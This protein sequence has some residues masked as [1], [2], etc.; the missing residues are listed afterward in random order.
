MCGIYASNTGTLFENIINLQSLEYRGYDSAGFVFIDKNNRLGIYKDVGNVSKL[1]LS[2]KEQDIDILAFMG[3]T[4][5]ATHGKVTKY[6]AHPHLDATQRYFI[7]HNGIVENYQDL[8]QKYNLQDKLK[9][10]T[11][12]EVLI[13]VV[14]NHCVNNSLFDS[15]KYTMQE[16]VGANSFIIL[17]SLNYKEF[18]VCNNGSKID[19][20]IS[21]KNNTISGVYVTSNS[22]KSFSDDCYLVKFNEE[23]F[24][25]R[26]SNDIDD[27]NNLY[28]IND[29]INNCENTI[30]K[31]GYEHFML[32]EIYEQPKMVRNLYSGRLY[33]DK[34]VLGGLQDLCKNNIDFDEIKILGC[35]SSLHASYIIQRYIEEISNIKTNVEQA[36]EFRYRSPV[37]SNKEL[38][39]CI[40][41][42]GETSDILEAMK[43]IKSNYTNRMMGI[44][45]TVGSSVSALSDFGI[46]TRAGKEVGVA[47]TKTYTNQI[48]SGLIFALYFHLREEII[49]ELLDLPTVI[50]NMLDNV[51]IFNQVNNTSLGIAKKRRCIFL[52]RGYNYPTALEGALKLK[53]LTYIYAHGYSASE[54]KHGPLALIDEN[55]E[56]I[57]IANSD[58]Q[59]LKTL[60]NASEVLCRHG[61]VTLIT[62][63]SSG[64]KIN[65]IIIPNSSKYVS[66]VLSNIVC[67]LIAYQT[68]VL[69]NK[70]V[71]QPRNLAKSVTVE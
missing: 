59:Y 19:M 45:N 1:M 67:Q 41:Q 39:I 54:M 47:S 34:I 37:I 6:N 60:N 2:V 40:S 32:K 53:E 3:H 17:D 29:K 33:S 52:G 8:I 57:V 36:G 23:K 30:D 49:L 58:D 64:M 27:T 9:S 44:C 5:W 55:T 62:D 51:D 71:D 28:S 61:N 4:R 68:A 14:A 11:D 43:Y 12:T 65:E 24:L 13:N 31:N 7:V 42:S 16:I 69:M 21:K 18:Y 66:P 50:Q 48:L 26:I 46:Y 25:K 56:V 70:N 20:F 15:I 22:G 10:E 35:G 38:F 63:K